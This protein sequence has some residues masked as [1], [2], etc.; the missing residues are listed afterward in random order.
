MNPFNG[1]L[2]PNWTSENQETGGVILYTIFDEENRFILATSPDK[3]VPAE[4]TIEYIWRV[5]AVCR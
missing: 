5:H 2:P 1:K 4:A 3:L